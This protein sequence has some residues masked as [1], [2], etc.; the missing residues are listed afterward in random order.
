MAFRSFELQKQLNT[1]H[2]ERKQSKNVSRDKKNQILY[3]IN[4][5]NVPIMII[6][7]VLWLVKR[8]LREAIVHLKCFI[9]V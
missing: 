7:R 2:L 8:L 5:C 4:R 1:R 3:L 9:K 6:L